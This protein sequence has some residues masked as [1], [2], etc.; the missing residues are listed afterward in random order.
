M[1][2]SSNL[3]LIPSERGYSTVNP[4]STNKV[5]STNIKSQPQSTSTSDKKVKTKAN[6]PKA[7]PKNKP[8][9]TKGSKSNSKWG[10]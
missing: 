9:P 1:A 8:I 5:T 4:P 2:F 10:K 3:T 6:K 7:K